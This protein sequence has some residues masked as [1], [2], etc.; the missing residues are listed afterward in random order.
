MGLELSQKQRQSLSPKMIQSTAVLQMDAQELLQYLET[1]VQENPVLEF[2]DQFREFWDENDKVPRKPNRLELT[3]FQNREYKH[4]DETTWDPFCRYAGGDDQEETL[5]DHLS[6]QLK[7][8]NLH[9]A[10][11]DCAHFLLDCLDS[12]GWL[13]ESLHI[14][15]CEMNQ[16]LSLIEKALKVV[17]SLEPAGIGARSLSECLSLQLLRR[18]PVDHLALCIA[19]DYLEAL[20]Q[21]HYGLIARETKTDQEEVRRAAALIRTLDP[22]PGSAFSVFESPRRII[23]DIIVNRMNDQWEISVNDRFLPALSINT[24]YTRMLKE[25]DDVQVKEYLAEKVRQARWIIQ[26]IEQRQSTLLACAEEIVFAQENFFKQ[27]APLNPMTMAILAQ[28]LGVHESTVSRAVN[29]KYLQCP[30]G[31]YPISYFFSRHLGY[32]EGSAASSNGAKEMLKALIAQENK[33]KP[34]S[35]QKIC[36]RMAE[37]GCIVSRRAIAKYRAELGIPGATGRK[38]IS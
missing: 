28:K 31:T 5:K 35:D 14:L 30:R 27:G 11:L 10:V 34:L 29:G 6:A 8:L 24:Y 23:P 38:Q 36:E 17:Q 15:A 2:D 3:D 19:Q 12:N 37:R 4:Q 9:P 25:N 32:A 1:S 21:H 13:T 33:S 16:P 18:I 22:R 7:A 20:A 26:A